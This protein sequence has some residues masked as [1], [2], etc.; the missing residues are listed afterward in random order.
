MHDFVSIKD[1]LPE[2]GQEVEAMRD[3]GAVVL[4]GGHHACGCR[5]GIERTRY[6]KGFVCDMISTGHVSHWRPAGSMQ[7]ATADDYPGLRNLLADLPPN[8]K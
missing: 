7:V 8:V 6:E 4:N 1:R 3:Y 5:F 2:A